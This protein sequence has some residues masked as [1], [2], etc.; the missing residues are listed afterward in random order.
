LLPGY[1]LAWN[2]SGKLKLLEI[3]FNLYKEDKAFKNHGEKKRKSK[4]Y[5]KLMGIQ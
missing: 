4:E 5:L 1:H 3:Y 2:T